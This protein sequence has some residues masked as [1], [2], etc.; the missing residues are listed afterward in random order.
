MPMWFASNT[1]SGL[2]T[3]SAAIVT[4]PIGFVV[5][6]IVTLL[7]PP[8][9]SEIQEL[10]DKV[11]HF[12]EETMKMEKNKGMHGNDVEGA[13]EAAPEKNMKDAAAL[14]IHIEVGPMPESS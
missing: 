6:V 8:P 3:I 14:P 13:V 12:D 5:M 4:M 10:G 9:P 11:R 1:Y 2:P 7:T